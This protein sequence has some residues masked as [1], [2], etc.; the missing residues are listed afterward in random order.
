MKELA[1]LKENQVYAIAPYY[2]GGYSSVLITE[3]GKL[4][5][6]KTVHEIMN[7]FCIMNGSTL[8]G[9]IQAARETTGFVKNPPIMLSAKG[10]FAMQ[11]PCYGFKEVLWV[12]NLNFLTQT[13]GNGPTKMVFQHNHY[14]EVNASDEKIQRYRWKLLEMQYLYDQIEPDYLK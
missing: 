9:C 13:I 11:L 1:Y 3:K 6:K 12:F 10:L 4:L 14:V 5:S 7:R 2:M 8:K